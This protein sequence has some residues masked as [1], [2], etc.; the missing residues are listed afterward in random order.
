[1]I[2]CLFSKVQQHVGMI[3]PAF[4]MLTASQ[5]RRAVRWGGALGSSVTPNFQRAS[6]N[7]FLFSNWGLYTGITADLHLLIGSNKKGPCVYF[8]QF[9]YWQHFIQVENTIKNRNWK[10][11]F[12][13][14]LIPIALA[15]LLFICVHARVLII[16]SPDWVYVSIITAET[17]NIFLL[18]RSVTLPFYNH[19]CLLLLPAPS[20]NS[21]NHCSPLIQLCHVKNQWNH[22]ASQVFRLAPSHTASLPGYSHKLCAS[23]VQQMVAPLTHWEATRLTLVLGYYH[24]YNIFILRTGC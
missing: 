11:I 14:H 9:P 18:H 24:T 8:L 17:Q 4:W 23:V 22:T 15:S 3:N 1:M 21:V 10:A 13:T 2:V 20:L 12:S 5:G 16:W 19:T 6:Y 7:T